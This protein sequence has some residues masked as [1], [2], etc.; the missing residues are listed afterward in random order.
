MFSASLPLWLP[1]PTVTASRCTP[2][3]TISFAFVATNSAASLAYKNVT[4]HIRLFGI[5]FT[6]CI[7]PPRIASHILS[8]V[9]LGGS[10]PRYIHR[11]PL[12]LTLSR[13]PLPP[14]AP[15]MPCCCCGC[16]CCCCGCCGCGCCCV[17]LHRSRQ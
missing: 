1:H 5:N 6:T 7:G 3:L 14:I 12:S 10:P 11:F 9:V 13:L 4:K 8:T 15:P 2:L 16:C 17:L